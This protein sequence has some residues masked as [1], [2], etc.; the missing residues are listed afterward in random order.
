MVLTTV[1]KLKVYIEIS[2]GCVCVSINAE[3]SATS[4]RG[5]KKE[6]MVGVVWIL[7]YTLQHFS[8]FWLL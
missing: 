4:I 5:N 3:M 6:E 2:T 8:V 1:M 7:V